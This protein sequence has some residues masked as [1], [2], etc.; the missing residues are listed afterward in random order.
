VDGRITAVNSEL[1]GAALEKEPFADGWLVKLA[2]RNLGAA[3]RQLFVA[4]EAREFLRKE[5]ANLR[6]YLAGLSLAGQ[7]SVAMA[8]LPEGGLPVDGLAERMSDEEWQELV[9]R[10]F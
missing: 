6:D 7:P 9:E 1:T 10:F 8:T 3:L 2:P 4:E 5:L